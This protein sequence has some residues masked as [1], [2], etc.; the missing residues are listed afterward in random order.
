MPDSCMAQVHCVLSGH[1][2]YDISRVSVTAQV[3]MA[4]DGSVTASG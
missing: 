3:L 1:M 2:H 4:E